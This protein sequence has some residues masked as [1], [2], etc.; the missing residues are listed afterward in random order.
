[1]PILAFLGGFLASS[2]IMLLLMSAGWGL[3][4]L[5]NL[6]T[7]PVEYEASRRAKKVLERMK[8]IRP[9]EETI[10]INKIL[11]AAALTYV[12]AFVTSIFSFFWPVFPSRVSSR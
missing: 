12:A 1:M 9:G 2:R 7:L 3:I 6:L 10:A 5:F 11:N 8:I 4:M